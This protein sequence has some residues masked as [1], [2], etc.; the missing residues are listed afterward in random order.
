MITLRNH[1]LGETVVKSK[2]GNFVK[3]V[4]VNMCLKKK[5]GITK[6]SKMSPAKYTITS[7]HI[8]FL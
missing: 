5:I 7:L 6:W 1:L 2:M 3:R 8:Y 4:V